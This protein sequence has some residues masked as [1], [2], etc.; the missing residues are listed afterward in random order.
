MVKVMSM[1]ACFLT[2][3]GPEECCVDAR[4]W[5]V[6]ARAGI[7]MR[8]PWGHSSWWQWEGKTEQRLEVAKLSSVGVVGMWLPS[9]WS[10]PPGVLCGKAVP[11]SAAPPQVW[12]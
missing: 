5:T 8:V 6:A 1:W 7:G 9:G 10:W 12:N 4:D 11:G 2:G 3:P